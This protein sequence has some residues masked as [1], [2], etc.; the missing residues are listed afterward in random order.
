V[1]T[2]GDRWRD[3]TALYEAAAGAFDA[4]TQGAAGN[5]AVAAVLGARR[6]VY[7]ERQARVRLVP[8]VS[9][10][11]H[12]WRCDVRAGQGRGQLLEP[13]SE[14]TLQRAAPQADPRPPSQTA[15]WLGAMLAED[16]WRWQPAPI[17][18]VAEAIDVIV[19]V[20]RD[21]AATEIRRRCP[22]LPAPVT[23]NLVLLLAGS[24]A[25][26]GLSWPGVVWIEA[27]LGRLAAETDRGTAAVINALVAGRRARPV[28]VIT[29]ANRARACAPVQL[30]NR[31]AHRQRGSS[32]VGL[33]VAS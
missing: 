24:R 17:E 19:D 16:G 33:A 22:D 32:V 20:G 27:H 26:D 25:R 21:R 7:W 29:D 28:N 30:R 13:I 1:V 31:D 10:G 2:S 15:P 4:A 12:R 8:P 18:A 14:E 11:E 9:Y 6:A 23:N 5:A 3:A